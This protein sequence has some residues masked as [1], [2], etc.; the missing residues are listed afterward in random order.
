MN[1]SSPRP[2][3][4][5]GT[6]DGGGLLRSERPPGP[7]IFGKLPAHGDFIARGLTPRLRKALDDWLSTGLAGARARFADFNERYRLAP[8]WHFVDCDP[9]GRWSGGALC[10]SV[11]AV[12]R[13]FPVLLAIPASDPGQAE[14]VARAALD[15]VFAALAEGWEAARL[16]DALAGVSP[17]P[18]AGSVPSH[19]AWAIEAEDGTRVEA[20]GRFPER[21]IERMLELAA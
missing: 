11:D 3:P 2:A 15:T 6:A 20:R 5:P 1:R 19:P 13:R 8:P 16:H 14:G 21:L 17:R 18:W 7:W 4:L 9:A 12:G 10:P